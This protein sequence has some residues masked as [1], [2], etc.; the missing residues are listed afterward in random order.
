MFLIR[1]ISDNYMYIQIL[2]N[3]LFDLI[4]EGKQWRKV[5]IIVKKYVL[6]Y[7][8]FDSTDA[9]DSYISI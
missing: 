3:S 8:Y 6:F 9:S 2:I 4:T 7:K 5:H 1:I